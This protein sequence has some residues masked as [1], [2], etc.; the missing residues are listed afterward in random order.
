MASFA[1][2]YL[3]IDRMTEAIK[4]QAP[5]V[6]AREATE[7]FKA[8]FDE[9]AFDGDPWPAAKRP[10]HT[11]SLMNRSGDLRNSIRPSMIT[12]NEVRIS[13]GGPKKSSR[14]ARIHNEGGT[15]RHPGGTAFVPMG[16]GADKRF[17]W[18]RKETAQ[19]RNF[20]RTKPHDIP[21]P[22]RQYMGYSRELMRILNPKLAELARLSFK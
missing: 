17:A 21:I 3:K 22:R 8:R 2:I 1:D 13:A 7:Y 5:V 18:V 9:K 4:Q 6:V 10:P 11:G 15:I 20:P 12:A 16:K 19:G 14:Y